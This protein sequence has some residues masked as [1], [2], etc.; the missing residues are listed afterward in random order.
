MKP[1]MR[2]VA[3]LSAAALV[4][5]AVA[6]SAGDTLFTMRQNVELLSTTLEEGLGLNE[7]RGVFSP[8]AGDVRG[9]YLQGQGVV[10]EVLTPLQTRE[11]FT[12]DAFSASLS[13]LSSQLDG[14]LQQ[15][16]MSRPDFEAMRDQLAMTLRSDEVAAYYRELMQQLQ[17]VQD[18]PAIER[19]LTGAGATLQSLQALG[20]I[21][22]ATEERLTRQLQNQRQQLQQ[23]MAEWENLRQQIRE[24][25]QQSDVMPD[26]ALQQTW[27]NAREQLERE[28]SALKTSIAEQSAQLQL[29]HQQAEQVRQQ[30]A[31]VALDEFQARLFVLLCDY[32]AS[33][34]ALPAGESLSVVLTGVGDDMSDGGRRDV[35]YQIERQALQSCLQGQITA[36]QLRRQAVSYQ[37]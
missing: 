28:L 6:Q 23:H 5:A 10:L 21:D 34:R 33:L 25:M 24:H 37:Y 8:R 7:R 29:Q 1:F 31:T 18:I 19:A 17:R 36:E 27:A 22:A 9:R 12:M 3:A 11:G 14:L 16:A 35:V 13:Q 20:Q 32:A 26:A 30:Q 4:P 2:Y 15:G